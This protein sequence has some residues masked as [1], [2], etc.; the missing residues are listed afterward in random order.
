MTVGEPTMR[1]IWAIILLITLLPCSASGFMS[2]GNVDSTVDYENFER[3]ED[4]Y[5]ITFLNKSANHK[6]EFYIIVLGFDFRGATVFRHRLYIDFLPGYGE[7][8]FFLPGHNDDILEVVFE[9]RHLYEYDV[10][11]KYQPAYPLLR[12]TPSR[13]H[14]RGK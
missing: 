5:T 10:W 7:L 8:S 14:R 12:S 6:A 9:V 1:V 11:P 4:G 2:F 3:K 13:R